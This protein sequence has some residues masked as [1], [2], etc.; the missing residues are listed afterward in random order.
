MF[1]NSSQVTSIL[2]D[3]SATA[4]LKSHAIYSIIAPVNNVWEIHPRF[5][6]LIPILVQMM[7]Q[8]TDERL[9]GMSVL[10]I[11]ALAYNEASRET[12]VQCGTR[13]APRLHHTHT[14]TH[15]TIIFRINLVLSTIN[16]SLFPQIVQRCNRSFA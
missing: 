8:E 5:R 11:G 3:S 2:T 12:L 1:H 10:C 9:R 14:H 7:R 16:I 13:N 15:I 6:P 4:T